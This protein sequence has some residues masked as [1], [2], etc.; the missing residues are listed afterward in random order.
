MRYP[1]TTEGG[2]DDSMHYA[3]YTMHYI[4]C[5]MHYILYTIYYYYTCRSGGKLTAII[6]PNRGAK[7]SYVEESSWKSN[8]WEL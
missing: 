2:D 5:T 8:S 3:L 4:L 7:D 1:I 6:L